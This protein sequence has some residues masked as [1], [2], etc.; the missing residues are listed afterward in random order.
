MGDKK[1]IDRGFITAGLAVTAWTIAVSFGLIL[2][3][4][5]LTWIFSADLNSSLADVMKFSLNAFLTM[6]GINLSIA[7]VVLGVKFLGFIFLIFFLL[8][9]NFKWSLK[10]L[11]TN[12]NS[13]LTLSALLVV[14]ISVL[15]Y[16]GIILGLYF[17]STGNLN[18]WW[19]VIVWPVSLSTSAGLFAI[20]A[21]GGGWAIFKAG[22]DE[23]SR[24]IIKSIKIALLAIATISFS[25]FIV[26]TYLSWQEVLGVFF[27]LGTDFFAVLIIIIL[28]IGWLP[29]YLLWIWS[30]LTGETLMLGTSKIS[31]VMVEISQLPAWPWFAILPET[32]P[33]WGRFLIAIPIF[34]GVLIAIFTYHKK[35]PNWLV[36]IFFS[37]LFVSFFLG[38]GLWFANGDLGL[39]ELAN[40]GADPIEQ[41][42]SSFRY[43][44]I[45]ATIVLVSKLLWER[46]T[47]VEVESKVDEAK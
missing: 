30:I 47:A 45:G 28:G 33:G 20:F 35:Y 37:S 14:V 12:R 6:N 31:L 43:F 16:S 2:I 3:L 41:F 18:D 38:T 21:V 44:I 46:A 15:S 27:D 24:N 40:F 17:L 34:I 8:Y 19:M 9:R 1:K 26:L 10:A 13:Q 22:L 4:S 29:N 39:E 32:I 25:F 11:L 36:G 7:E 23:V 5:T 42:K